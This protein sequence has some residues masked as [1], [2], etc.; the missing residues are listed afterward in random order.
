MFSQSACLIKQGP[1]QNRLNCPQ[2]IWHLPPTSPAYYLSL[3]ESGHFHS[4][5]SRER[6]NIASS[7][8]FTLWLGQ[9]SFLTS[10]FKEK[11]TSAKVLILISRWQQRITSSCL[12]KCNIWV[13]NSKYWLCWFWIILYRTIVLLYWKLYN[14]HFS[15]NTNG[16]PIFNMM[17]LIYFI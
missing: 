12:N 4:R 1:S 2:N 6:L 17:S 5:H 9:R 14:I 10:A 3:L 13:K 11:V 7:I 15:P 8:V 16:S